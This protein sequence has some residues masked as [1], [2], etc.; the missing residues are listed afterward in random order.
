MSNRHLSRSVALQSLFEWDFRGCVDT[1]IEEI[2]HRNIDEFAPGMNEVAFI[3][4]LVKR[5]L[6]NRP[7]IDS[8][9]EKAAPD[10]PLP[11]ISP[12][13]RNV[14]RLGLSELLFAD[15]KEVPAKVAIN[16][17]IELAKTFGGETSG[18]FVNGV[19]GTVYKE[20]GEPG[21]DEVSKKKPRSNEP[22]DP[23]TLPLEKKGGALVYAFAEGD[24]YVALVHDIFGYWTLPKGGIEAEEDEKVGTSREITEE[25]GIPVTVEDLLGE[26]EYIASNPEKG[27]I[28]KRV[29]YFLA[30]AEKEDL[31][32]KQSGGLDDARWFPIQ[33]LAELTMYDDM[34]PV[35]TKAVKIISEKNTEPV[36]A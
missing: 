5:V 7:T 19:L 18:R 14:L 2:V 4:A 21:K 8:I 15:K 20:M 11:Q 25:I 22:V 17:A 36:S 32:L 29:I 6:E 13:D 34:L 9:I 3:F 23:A 24:A 35:I 12:V 10:W 33:E 26:N 28:R 30:R 31:K 16:E 1:D 27:K